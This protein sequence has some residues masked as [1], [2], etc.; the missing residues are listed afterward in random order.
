MIYINHS[1]DVIANE[2]SESPKNIIHS[3][4]GYPFEWMHK[5]SEECYYALSFLAAGQFVACYKDSF[6]QYPMHNSGMPMFGFTAL[7]VCGEFELHDYTGSKQPILESSG[8]VSR[9]R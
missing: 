8:N 2:H 5:F 6:D 9:R 4:S 7:L 1:K 3:L